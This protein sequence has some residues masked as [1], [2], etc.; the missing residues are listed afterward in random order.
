MPRRPFKVDIK[1]QNVLSKDGVPVNVDAVGLVRIGA[2]SEAVQTAVQ[3]FLTS[4]LEELQSQINE[5]LSGN[6]RGI[7]ATMTVE[8]LNSRR[9]VLSR[10]V[11][12]VAGSALAKI[13]MEVDVLTIAGISDHN[14]YLD[15]LGQRRIA[16]V[17]RD[18]TVGTAEADRD[19]Q[20]KS[21][22]ARQEGAIAQARADTAIATANQER[23]VELARLRSKT[24]SENAMADQAGPLAHA[25]AM[26]DVGIANE[27]AEAARVQA[28]I[29]VEARRAEQTKAALRADVIEPAE[30]QRQADI[31]KAEGQ[32]QAEILT[33]QARAEAHRQA[34]QA[35][36]DARKLTA[37]ALRAEKQA[38][39]D[40]IQAMLLAEAAG[41]AKIAEALNSYTAD[42]ARL[43]MLPDALNAMIESTKAASAPLSEI[44]RLSIIGGAGDAKDAIGGLLG[45]SPL[46]IAKSLESLKA[47]GIDIAALLNPSK[48]EDGGSDT[49]LEG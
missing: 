33:A 32:R 15:A 31:A 19:A 43:L 14:G 26:K 49:D 9:D 27:E 21:A 37:E 40:G 29:D 23:D 39:A 2:S 41:K 17:R 10:E 34:G 1:L 30:A 20:I 22:Q 42:A 8:E 46:S 6:L 11:I 24:E 3:R 5:I 28:R 12:D 18:A 44:E 45:I 47:S 38:E 7:V 16:E 36:A 13:G 4:N 35:E 48:V 25:R